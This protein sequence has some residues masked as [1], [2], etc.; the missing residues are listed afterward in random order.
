MGRTDYIF[1]WKDFLEN[2]GLNSLRPSAF[3]ERAA[4]Q[5]CNRFN[6]PKFTKG[7]KQYLDKLPDSITK[8]L[9]PYVE[10]DQLEIIKAAYYN[11]KIDMAKY[12]RYIDGDIMFWIL[13]LFASGYTDKDIAGL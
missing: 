9:D 7:Q 1:N 8:Q 3:L 4:E 6:K 12:W 10:L 5:N 11:F 13:M 2:T